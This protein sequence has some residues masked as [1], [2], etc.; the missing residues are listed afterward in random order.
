MTSN[1]PL[2]I[3]KESAE[4]ISYQPAK[5][6]G[7]LTLFLLVKP[8]AIKNG[9]KLKLVSK[10]V[11]QWGTKRLAVIGGIA[12]LLI[13][14]SAVMTSYVFAPSYA[15][16]YSQLETA[17]AGQIISKLDTLG[18]PYKLKGDGSQIWVHENEA[19][20]LRMTLAQEGLPSSGTVGYEIFDRTESLGTTSFQQDLNYLRA[21]EGEIAK[22]LR[23]MK[24]IHQARV[25]LVIPKREL[26]ATEEKEP[27]ASVFLKTKFASRLPDE[28]IRAI[29]HLVASAV[30]GLT[31]SNIT[32]VDQ[33]GTVLAA[34]GDS[35][36]DPSTIPAASYG[37]QMR[38]SIQERFGRNIES[39]LE[40]IVGRGKSRAEVYVD[41]DLDR[42]S[43][44]LETYDPDSQVARSVQN[45]ED[46]SQNQNGGQQNTVGIQ[47]NLPGQNQTNQGGATN[48]NK[49]VEE[50][51]NYEI[52]KTTK[53]HVHETG[54]IQR[55]S[56]AVMVDGTYN[57]NQEYVP[58]PAEEL[59]RIEELVKTA[60]G[61]TEDRGDSVKVIT[62]PFQKE[63]VEFAPDYGSN[64]FGLEAKD[65]FRILE[66]L[67]YM[68]VFY[69]FF[70]YLLTPVAKSVIESFRAEQLTRQMEEELKTIKEETEAQVAEAEKIKKA[71][72]KRKKAANTPGATENDP[73]L[74]YNDEDEDE[75]GYSPSRV[76]LAHFH[77]KER[78]TKKDV[79]YIINAYPAEAANVI[80]N[81]MKEAK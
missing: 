47:N 60:V 15:L 63:V 36:S 76:N 77:K 11:E 29:Q 53:T 58:R 49:K 9:V 57:D 70:R 3:K 8:K 10:F 34:G 4:F 35:Q 24:L 74:P 32:I 38:I 79:E 73:A 31:P 16:L 55:L 45:S 54:V 64:F 19:P 33:N 2:S 43:E 27:T 40:K 26:F 21:L 66:I 71:A 23:S 41:L 72:E 6:A 81:W 7:S 80:Y 17:D 46:T 69:F 12:G 20:K 50:T 5:N 61:F 59:S 68:F 62:M 14:L 65:L 56:V 44:T 37:D 67:A 25:H 75:E 52:S 48:I 13:I 42:V 78:N 22:S 18:T 1:I 39:M 51:I 28:T 30:K